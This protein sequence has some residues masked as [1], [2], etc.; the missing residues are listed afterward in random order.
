MTRAREEMSFYHE[1]NSQDVS[2]LQEEMRD[3]NS[4]DI[5][6]LGESFEKEETLAENTIRTLGEAYAELDEQHRAIR[7]F[8]SFFRD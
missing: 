1:F 8:E 6:A 3:Y 2:Y 4:Q 7:E 5:M